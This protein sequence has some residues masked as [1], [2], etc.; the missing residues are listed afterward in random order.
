MTVL[1]G[2]SKENLSKTS[3]PPDTWQRLKQWGVI[4]LVTLTVIMATLSLTKP[5]ATPLSAT[6]LSGLVGLKRMAA[7]TM[8]YENAIASPNPTLIEFYADWCTTCQSMSPTVESLHQQYGEQINFVML[9]IDDPQ[10]A[11]QIAQYSATGVPQF[12]LLDAT[13]ESVETW[14]GKVPKPIFAQAIAQAISQ[15]A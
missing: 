1:S 4:A 11:E 8:P 6:P 2:S 3:S 9:D 5:A 12:T 10:W 15:D 14:V 7:V 13:N